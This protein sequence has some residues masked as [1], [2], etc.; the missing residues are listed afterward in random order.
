[1]ETRKKLNSIDVIIVLI[2]VILIA[3]GAYAIKQF[4]GSGEEKSKTIVVEVREQKESLCNILKKDDI[5]YD[6]VEN[7]KL[8]KVVN[9]EVLPAEIDSISTLSGTIENV[10]IPERYDILLT[11]EVPE[12]TK[13]QVGKQ[14]WIETSLYKC[15]GYV[16]EVDDG[17]KAALEE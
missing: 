2:A 12:S 1:M 7:V 17:G 16:L 10:L 15:S 13:V 8:G 5:A 11:I 3:G 6:G 4:A 14:L 9:Y